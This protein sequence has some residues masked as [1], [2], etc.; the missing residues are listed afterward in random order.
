MHVK[1]LIVMNDS[2]LRSQ[3][4]LSNIL[5]LNFLFF[6]LFGFEEKTHF[7]GFDIGK[8]GSRKYFKTMKLTNEIV[9]RH[10]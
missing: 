10:E 4:D 6:F 2:S 3:W 8:V 9:R 7:R 5:K 1:V